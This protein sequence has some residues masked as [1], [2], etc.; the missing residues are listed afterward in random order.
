MHRSHPVLTL[1]AARQCAAGRLA[2]RMVAEKAQRRLRKGSSMTSM[3][4][5]FVGIGTVLLGVAGVA[6]HVHAEDGGPAHRPSLPGAD[7]FRSRVVSSG[8]EYPYEVTWGP[9]GYLWVTERTGKRVTRIHPVDGSKRTALELP[10]V[11]QSAGQDGLLGMALHP[12][13]LHGAGKDYVY[14]A[15]TYDAAAR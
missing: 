15:F 11:H 5:R 9:D 4:A 10:E 3:S 14:L 1:M 12:E 7:A 2:C 6:S 13:L 8:L